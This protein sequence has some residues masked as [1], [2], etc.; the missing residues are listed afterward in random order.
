MK[1]ITAIVRMEQV[2]DVIAAVI[3][4][5]ARGMTVTD[6]RGFGRQHGHSVTGLG[7]GGADGEAVLLPMARL[8]VIAWDRDIDG[9]VNCVAAHAHTGEIGDGKIWVTPVESIM[10]VR[11]S[12]RDAAAV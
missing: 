10:R 2:D 5:G 9:L 3:R 12:E 11:T 4:G 1:L 7:A 6:T 8:D